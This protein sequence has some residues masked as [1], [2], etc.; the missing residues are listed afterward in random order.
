MAVDCQYISEDDDA[1]SG[2]LHAA[3]TVYDEIPDADGRGSYG[4]HPDYRTVLH[5][6]EAVYRRCGAV[7]NQGLIFEEDRRNER[8]LRGGRQ[9]PSPLFCTEI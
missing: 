4:S 1:R 9:K 7:R 3:G 5:L 8:N 6:P 2:A